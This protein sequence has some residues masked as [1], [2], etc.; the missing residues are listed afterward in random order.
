MPRDYRRRAALIA[1][2]DQLLALALTVNEQG[3][4][5]PIA[6]RSLAMAADRYRRAGLTGMV[7]RAETIL[8]ETWGCAAAG[9]RW[10]PGMVELALAVDA[11]TTMS[12]RPPSWAELAKALGVSLVTARDRAA[13]ARARGL[14]TWERGHARTLKVNRVEAGR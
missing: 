7:E 10:T 6:V 1:A 5:R 13:E 11:I 14:V 4:H 8:S 2:A 12:G 9:R 3:G